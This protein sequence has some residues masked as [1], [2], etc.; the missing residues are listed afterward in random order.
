[1][2][3]QMANPNDPRQ[4]DDR[5]AKAGRVAV[6]ETRRPLVQLGLLA[7]L[8]AAGLATVQLAALHHSQPAQP[9]FLRTELGAQQRSTPLVRTP[10]RG[11]RVAI[12]QSGTPSGTPA[13]APSRS[14]SPALPGPTRSASRTA[15]RGRPRSAARP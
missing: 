10:A 6:P 13:T 1:M 11:L 9:A 15:S 12:R 14:T 7:V 2:A 4:R 5:P 3:R 8:A